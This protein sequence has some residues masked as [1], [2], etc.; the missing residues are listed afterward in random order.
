MLAQSVP[1]DYFTETYYG[2]LNFFC[3]Y[4]GKLS[5]RKALGHLAFER[6]FKDLIDTFYFDMG[7]SR[8]G[9]SL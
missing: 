4:Y 7:V 8:K 6:F 1:S 5:K 9:K 3:P 2:I